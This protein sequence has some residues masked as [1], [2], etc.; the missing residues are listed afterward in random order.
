MSL[1][2]LAGALAD[3]DPP[4]AAALLRESRAFS[5]KL[6]YENAGQLAQGVLVAARLRDRPLALEYARPAIRHLHWRGDRPQLSGVLNVVAWALEDAEPDAAATIQGAARALALAD[7]PSFDAHERDPAAEA[8][9]PTAAGVGFI[10]ELRRGTTRRLNETLGQE[11]RH[12]QRQQ[13]ELMDADQAVDYTL[14]HVA[15]TVETGPTECP[16]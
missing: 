8:R 4:R 6:N 11:R 13:G 5:E 14:A 7:S 3:Q 2:A 12:E 10:T 16:G 1:A 15:G 9:Q